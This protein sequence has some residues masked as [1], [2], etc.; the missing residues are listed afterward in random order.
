MLILLDNSLHE[1]TRV[2]FCNKFLTAFAHS[3]S[4]GLPDWMVQ[5]HVNPLHLAMMR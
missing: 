1:P 5:S 2:G 4:F 3:L